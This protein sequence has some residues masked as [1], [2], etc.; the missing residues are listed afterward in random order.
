MRRFGRSAHEDDEPTG[1]GDDGRRRRRTRTRVACAVFGPLAVAAGVAGVAAV[2]HASGNPPSA[3]VSLKGTGKTSPDGYVKL[4]W[5][6]PSSS[7][8]SAISTYGFD[9]STNG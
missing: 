7:G 3:P 1:A 6:A 8:T 5:K 4:T 9:V 2:A